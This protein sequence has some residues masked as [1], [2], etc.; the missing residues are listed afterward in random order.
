MTTIEIKAVIAL[1]LVL[2]LAGVVWLVDRH[3]YDRGMAACHA[4]QA[5]AVTKAEVKQQAVVVASDTGMQKAVDAGAQVQAQ[6]EQKTQTVIRTITKVI[7]DAPSPAVCTVQ[8]DSLR[9]LTAAT[10]RANAA[11]DRL[12]GAGAGAEA[13]RASSVAKP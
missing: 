10:A 7:H 8:P 13:A 11:A 2:L 6:A 9:E 4:A 3:G 1:A 5:A 12:Q